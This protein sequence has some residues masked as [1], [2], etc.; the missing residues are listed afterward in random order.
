MKDTCVVEDSPRTQSF[1]SRHRKAVGWLGGALVS[2]L[3]A[4]PVAW[5]GIGDW[6][7]LCP[8]FGSCSSAQN[9]PTGESNTSG[10]PPDGVPSPSDRP[11]S[12]SG[13][14]SLD[15]GSET[16]TLEAGTIELSEGTSQRIDATGWRVSAGSIFDTFANIR[17]T[18]DAASCEANLDVGQNLVLADQ[19][20][21]GASS[22]R[23]FAVALSSSTQG[24]AS[25]DWSMG[26]GAAPVGV[27]WVTCD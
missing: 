22:K 17:A 2:A 6:R 1:W 7:P 9:I 5:T 25:I 16:R 24:R 10:L 11:Q 19:Q 14:P 15:P 21:S 12:P 13:S 26:S 27:D 23:W 20:A 4:V 18:T 3:I 8:G